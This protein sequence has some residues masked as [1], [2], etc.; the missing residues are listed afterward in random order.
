[1]INV[2]VENFARGDSKCYV[3]F[4]RDIPARPLLR[5]DKICLCDNV[6]VII[7]Q[8]LFDSLL[9]IGSFRIILHVPRLYQIPDLA[10]VPCSLSLS[11]FFK[12]CAK[13]LRCLFE[14]VAATSERYL[15]TVH[16]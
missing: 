4:V 16:R 9:L 14:Q 3:P 2:T 1:M 11:F 15:E 5:T 8:P 12:A 7:S 6:Y 10:F 13:L